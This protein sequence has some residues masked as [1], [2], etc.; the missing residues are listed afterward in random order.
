MQ[1]V[2]RRH[3][4]QPGAR[5]V[6]EQCG[7][8]GDRFRRHGA[9]IDDRQL[10]AFDGWREPIASD[11][12]R[13][14]VH[15]R[16]RAVRLRDVP[17]RQAQID[18][19]AVLR[20]HMLEAP[21]H[22]RRQLVGKGGFEIGEAGNRHA[23]QR[24]IDRLMRTSLG[25]QGHARRRAR[26]HEAGVL[27][28]GVIQRVEPAVY[29]RVVQRPNR[30]QPR[31]EQRRRKAERRQHQEQIVLRD[32]Q[33]EM[34]ARLRPHP[35]LDRGDVL[36]AEH[37]RPFVPVEQAAL[38]DPGAEIGRHGHVRRG[39][40]HRRRQAAVT[41]AE[42]V[43]DLAEGLLRRCLLRRRQ[44]QVR[45]SHRWRTVPPV[46]FLR[47]GHFVEESLQVRRFD[48]EPREAVPF[49][50]FRH[51]HS[52][53]EV[54]HLL[55]VHHAGV[56]V[57][58]TGERRTVALDR[59]RDE[60]AGRI[61]VR[62]IGG[63]HRLQ[64]RGHVVTGEVGHQPVQRRVVMAV[65]ERL[66]SRRAREVR[67]QPLAPG[68]GALEGQRRIQIVRALVD[69]LQHR[70]ARRPVPRGFQLLAILQGHDV[71]VDGAEEALDFLEQH[72]VDDAVEALAVVIDDPPQIA[73][74]VFPAFKQRFEDIAFVELRIAH[75]RHHA[76]RRDAV[77]HVSVQPRIVLYQR[78]EQR[79]GHAEPDRAGREIDVSAVLGS[80]RIGLRAAEHAEV[81]QHGNVLPAQH[82]HQRVVNRA[83][84]RFDRDAVFRPQHVHIKRRQKRRG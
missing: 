27:V 33:F 48:I 3:R 50:A 1:A 10:R 7:V 44:G 68:V 8:R 20:L 59:V 42:I 35:F 46:L 5:H 69:P 14:S 63:V 60:A 49:C 15:L 78:R 17:R 25:R 29:E 2:R 13:G 43:Q 38:V 75:Q 81:P 30:Q 53:A 32:A 71:P 26:D 11:G 24:R 56:V 62:G 76:A 61:T 23:D 80:R 6:I 36:L 70:F 74:I 67:F 66:Q 19:A 21:S 72:V 9:G 52:A 65:E 16:Q 83:R 4:E 34:L 79:F 28:A 47:E 51:R 77:A 55:R 84:M 58:V 12:N 40:D 37:V 31:A 18:R 73:D 22:D 64:D 82:V 45:H 39:A 54:V 57:L 41:A